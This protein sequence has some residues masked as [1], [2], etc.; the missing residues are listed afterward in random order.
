MPDRRAAPASYS[1]HPAAHRGPALRATPTSTGGVMNPATGRIRG[2][3]AFG[4]AGRT[5]ALPART[6]AWR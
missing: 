1:P 3:S 4:R 6:D 2:R 5:A